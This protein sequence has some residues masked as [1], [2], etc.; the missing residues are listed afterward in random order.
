MTFMVT[1]GVIAT[2]AA[3]ATTT[4]LTIDS[5]NKSLKS[6]RGDSTKQMIEDSHYKEINAWADIPGALAPH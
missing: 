1:A 5:T 3:T 2:I 6:Q 4:G